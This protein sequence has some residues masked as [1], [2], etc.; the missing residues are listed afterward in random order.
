MLRVKSA[1]WLFRAHR[2]CSSTAN[3]AYLHSLITSQP[4]P[5]D[6]TVV[7]DEYTAKKA[8]RVL[9]LLEDEPGRIHACDTE[10]GDIN[11]ARESPVGNG[12]VTCASVYSGP[13]VDFG[14]GPRLW[15]D[16]LGAAE[17]TLDLFKE[18]FEG[19]AAKK[20]WHNYSFDRA[21][22]HNHGVDCMGLGGDTMHMAR[23]WDTARL[24]EGG[25]SLEALTQHLLGTPKRNMKVRRM[26]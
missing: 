13:D 1:R 19:K 21:V 5:Q 16:N 25:Y 12:T 7:R 20:V 6:T 9:K 8:L 23:L 2:L 4:P 26:G 18:F 11:L 24:T 10:V 14:T 17:G 22:M 3:P 15:I